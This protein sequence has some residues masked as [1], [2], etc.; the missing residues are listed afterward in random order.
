M[1]LLA[2]LFRS[3]F[4]WVILAILPMFSDVAK[5]LPPMAWVGIAL[6]AWLK[7]FKPDTTTTDN[8]GSPRDQLN[9]TE[10]AKQHHTELPK[11]RVFYKNHAN[12]LEEKMSAAF[13]DAEGI[14]D[15]L[16]DWSTPELLEL[17]HQFGVRT[18]QEFG[19]DQYTGNLFIWLEKEMSGM[20]EKDDLQRIK[21]YFRP[22][23][24]WS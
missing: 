11:K 4:K 8:S 6:V 5:K 19:F 12:W 20:F 14:A 18:R 7:W 24:L 17:Y 1:P 21:D 16:K 15:S 22:T 3:G 13:T 23:G 9:E 10:E 2:T